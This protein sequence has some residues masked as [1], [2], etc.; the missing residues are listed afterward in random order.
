MD[1][2]LLAPQCATGAQAPHV[3]TC[4][5]VLVKAWHASKIIRCSISFEQTIQSQGTVDVGATS[6]C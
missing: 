2:Y 1:I 3:E 5:R 6:I 4:E